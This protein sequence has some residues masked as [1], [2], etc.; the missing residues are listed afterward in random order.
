M[1]VKQ[2]QCDIKTWMQE[3]AWPS[4]LSSFSGRD[5]SKWWISLH[6]NQ[7]DW[8]HLKFVWLLFMVWCVK[9][10]CASIH[11][12]C[13]FYKCL[14]TPPL[15]LKKITLRVHERGMAYSRDDLR[16]LPLSG[17]LGALALVL[18]GVAAGQIA[19]FSPE[20]FFINALGKTVSWKRSLSV[21]SKL[22]SS[23]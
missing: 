13:N 22:H 20:L 8:K 10:L 2:N 12:W 18:I 9:S 14:E 3:E 11:F 5:L 17:F 16:P 6:W 19:K 15:R 21:P 23:T 4:Q 1:W 7:W